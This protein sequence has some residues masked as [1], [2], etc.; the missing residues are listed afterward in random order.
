MAADRAG[1]LRDAPRELPAQGREIRAER[2]GNAGRQPE[3]LRGEQVFYRVA[4]VVNRVAHCRM[5]RASW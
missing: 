5:I 1:A 3:F 4:R 2:G